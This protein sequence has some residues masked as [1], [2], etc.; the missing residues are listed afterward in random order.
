VGQILAAVQ[1]RGLDGI[2]ITEHYNKEYGFKVKEMVA[3]Y[4]N[5]EVLIIPG[6]EIDAGDEQVVELF[7][8]NH[9]IFRFLAHPGYLGRLKDVPDNIQGIEI[10]NAGH[11]WHINKQQV[12]QVAEDKGLL[13]LHNSDAHYLEKIGQF[14]NELDLDELMELAKSNGHW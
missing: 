4:F 13:L 12:R 8:P 1:A 3:Q 7:L 11:N 6:H 10:D 14:H 2:G 5:N 9:A